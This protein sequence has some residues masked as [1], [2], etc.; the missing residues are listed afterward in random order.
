MKN[1]RKFDGGARGELSTVRD[2]PAN[3]TR[4]F[5]EEKFWSSGI[6]PLMDLPPIGSKHKTA[7]DRS[8]TAPY[9]SSL[10]LQF[11]EN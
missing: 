7:V 3:L 4:T 2:H 5:V 8:S 10:H 1:D 9:R 6:L 11:V